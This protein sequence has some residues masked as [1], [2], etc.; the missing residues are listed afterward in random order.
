MLSTVISI[1]SRSTW[2]SCVKYSTDTGHLSVRG[3]KQ[4]LQEDPRVGEIPSFG[5]NLS[6]MESA[7]KTSINWERKI[8]T[9]AYRSSAKVFLEILW[10][11]S[12]LERKTQDLL[13]EYNSGCTSQQTR[14]QV[15]RC[16]SGWECKGGLDNKK[17]REAFKL[18]KPKLSI[19]VTLGM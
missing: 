10:Y 19:Y 12:R 15:W 13:L 17:I 9:V 3:L 8:V 7:L 5:N 18:W 2:Q 14:E 1:E 4:S 6:S 16:V 11:S